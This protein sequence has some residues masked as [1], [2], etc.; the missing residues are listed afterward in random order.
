M[1]TAGSGASME[2]MHAGVLIFA[3]GLVLSTGCAS[4]PKKLSNTE[5]ARLH[6]EVAAAALMENDSVSAL[7]SIQSAEKEDPSLPEIHPARSIAYYLKHDLATAA[8]EAAKAVRMKPDYSDANSTLG[9]ILLDQGKYDQAIPYLTAAS[10][11]PLYRDAHK[12]FTNLGVLYYKRGDFRNSEQNLES[13]IV[14]SPEQ[15]CVA[16]YY[17]GHLRLKQSR[18]SDAIRDYDHATRRFCG[19]FADAHL[20]L[21]IAYE[22]AKQYDQARK[23]Y[24]DVQKR[25]PSTKL[26]EQAMNRLKELP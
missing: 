10:K 9:K 8:A 18:F 3:L 1:S 16:Y 2:R 22:Y 24:L 19:S 20:A 17:R 25:Y 6:L 26:A 13:A 15:A 23:K 11:D 14:A 7:T 21:G 4:G 12:P 5:K